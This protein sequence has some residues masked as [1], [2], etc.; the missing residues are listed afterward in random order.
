MS[1]GVQASAYSI[2]WKSNLLNY[3]SFS[4]ADIFIDF[5]FVHMNIRYNFKCWQRIQSS[6]LG[7]EQ[8]GQRPK[9]ASSPFI[10]VVVFPFA[11]LHA[12]CSCIFS[13]IQFHS[14]LCVLSHFR[15]TLR[16]LMVHFNVS[17]HGERQWPNL[18][19]KQSV[20][21]AV[22]ISQLN[23]VHSWVMSALSPAKLH[24]HWEVWGWFVSLFH[25]VR[26]TPY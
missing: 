20:K 1:D 5:L 11:R 25:T 8:A 24:L 26:N 15:K 2:L 6:L 21:P 23:T 22:D 17:I 3:T 13:I 7:T 14:W 9:M 12:L 10:H 16:H 18:W 19:P 4:C